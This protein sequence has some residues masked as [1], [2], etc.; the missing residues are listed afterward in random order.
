[1][2]FFSCLFGHEASPV[3]KTL[4]SIQRWSKEFYTQATETKINAYFKFLVKN[5]SKST[6]VIGKETFTDLKNVTSYDYQ[7]CVS[8]NMDN[9]ILG[10]SSVIYFGFQQENC[11]Y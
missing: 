1:M 9:K 10:L 11:L 8:K 7:I 4:K 6:T 5:Q 2:E 3:N